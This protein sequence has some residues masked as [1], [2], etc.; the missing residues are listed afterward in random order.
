MSGVNAEPSTVPAGTASAAVTSSESG[1]VDQSR[2]SDQESRESQ[3]ITANSIQPSSVTIIPPSG[4]LVPSGFVFVETNYEPNPDVSPE[5]VAALSDN[6]LLTGLK[7]Q[8]KRTQEELD[9]FIVFFDAAV[10]RYS[11]EQPRTASG[12][13]LRSD[14]PTLPEAFAA[15]GLSYET[16]RKRKQRYLAA[17]RVRFAMPKPLLLAE[18]DIVKQKDEA[19]SPEYTVV[20][21]HQSAP[22]VDVMRSGDTSGKVTTLPSDSLKKVTPPI[23]KVKA[24]DLIICEDN[25]A[26]YRYEGGGRFSRTKIPTLLEQKRE[27]ELSAIEARKER[28]AAKAESKKRKRELQNAEAARRDLERIAENERR[29]AEIDAKKQAARQRKA[30]ATSRRSKKSAN[31]ESATPS[32]AQRVKVAR[33]GN[34]QEFG[35]YEDPC[36]D[37]TTKNATTIGTREGCEAERDRINAK[38]GSSGDATAATLAVAA[39][40]SE[41]RRADLP[42]NKVAAKHVTHSVRNTSPTSISWCEAARR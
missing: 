7:K 23:R 10:E 12:K 31:E 37:Y 30:A 22:K 16:E 25:G 9:A 15:I 3:S 18:G 24:G 19:G 26:E 33:I 39:G 29:K 14:K 1:E 5:E 32:K 21:V 13:F 27:R 8:R 2:I 20:S 17:M 28:E 40:A 4:T 36:L 11:D 42:V 35:V 38:R 6:D 41:A 34:T